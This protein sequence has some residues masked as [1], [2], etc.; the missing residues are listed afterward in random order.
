MVS[1]VNLGALGE[2]LIYYYILFAVYLVYG[3]LVL[4]T[5]SLASAFKIGHWKAIWKCAGRFYAQ[6]SIAAVCDINY[7]YRPIR[8][9]TSRMALSRCAL[10]FSLPNR[11]LNVVSIVPVAW[12]SVQFYEP[13]CWWKLVNQPHLARLE[14][15][16]TILK[17]ELRSLLTT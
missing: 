3:V 9:I 12:P 15:H 2:R 13:H 4:P 6:K 10:P 1:P 11:P 5:K 16:P 8:K 14:P 7:V 17:T